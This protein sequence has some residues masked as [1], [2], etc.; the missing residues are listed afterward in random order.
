M[1]ILFSTIPK[2]QN[3]YLVKSVFI[4]S[5]APL[6]QSLKS[7][8]GLTPNFLNKE[9]FKIWDFQILNLR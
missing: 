6:R 3:Q 5:P 9:A 4:S 1:C 8:K 2:K 7:Y